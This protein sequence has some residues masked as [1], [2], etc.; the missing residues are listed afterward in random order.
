MDKCAFCGAE[1]TLYSSNVPICIQCSRDES[2]RI[3]GRNI[4]S[5][6]KPAKVTNASISVD[7]LVQLHSLDVV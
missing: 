6:E 5:T 2:H 3:S 4:Q 7:A 1:T